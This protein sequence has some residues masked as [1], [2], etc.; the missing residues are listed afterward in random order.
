MSVF[1]LSSHFIIAC[2][3]LVAEKVEIYTYSI[4]KAPTSRCFLQKINLL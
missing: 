1:R 2:P 3:K 4:E